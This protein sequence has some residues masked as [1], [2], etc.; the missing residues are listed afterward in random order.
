MKLLNLRPYL[1]IDE[2]PFE[3]AE[4]GW[5]EFEVQIKL[6]FVDVNE[7]PVN[8]FYQKLYRIYFILLSYIIY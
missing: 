4:S 2:P 7:K 1:V 6:Y 5:G 3:L 8:F